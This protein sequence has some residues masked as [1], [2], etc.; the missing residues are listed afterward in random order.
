M[1]INFFAFS[2]QQS[3]LIKIPKAA[4]PGINPGQTVTAGQ[5]FGA[6]LARG[7]D[8]FPDNLLFRTDFQVAVTQSGSFYGDPA[9]DKIISVIR[10]EITFATTVLEDLR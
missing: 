9:T 4:L 6:V 7:V 2:E 5:F 3:S 10:H 1:T 8:Y